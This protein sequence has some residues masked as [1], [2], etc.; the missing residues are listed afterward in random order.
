MI[1]KSIRT[2]LLIGT[3][4]AVAPLAHAELKVATIDMNR[5]FT[6]YYKTKDAEAKL[7]EQRAGAKKEFDDR[8]ETLKKS[9]EEITKLNAK[10]ESPELSKDAKDAI[11]KDRETKV[12]EARNLDKEVNEF[13]GTRER[14]L[15][16]QFL[17]MR[18]DIIDDI[19]KVVTARVSS[20]GYDLVF[21]KSGLSMGQIPV[22]IYSRDD[23]DFSKDIISK[24]NANA[25][26]VKPSAQ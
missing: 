22:V 13:K 2:L 23:M 10:I 18:K 5:V 14:Q 25:P 12:A 11:L 3:I 20:A 9:M 16:E 17:R 19:M 15:Q 21:D 8:I 26:K 6:E 1:Q 24:L 4:G 7:N